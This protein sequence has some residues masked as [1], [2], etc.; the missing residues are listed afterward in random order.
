M[1]KHGLDTD[2][3]NNAVC[4]VRHWQDRE[5][6]VGYLLFVYGTIPAERSVCPDSHAQS[7][8]V[9][10]AMLQ[11]RLTSI[12]ESDGCND[13]K[14]IATSIRD[15]LQQCNRQIYELA[16]YLGQS[17]AIGGAVMFLHGDNC[18]ATVFGG[19]RMFFWDGSQL[20]PQGN[21]PPADGLITDALGTRPAWKNK[22]WHGKLNPGQ[23]FLCTSDILPDIARASAIIS[24]NGGSGSHEN[25]VAMLLRKE[26]ELR[27]IPP[28]AVFEVVCLEQAEQSGCTEEADPP[29]EF[30]AADEKG[31]VDNL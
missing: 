5:I 15:L 21:V 23:R 3:T 14:Y 8:Q 17:I 28:S 11:K 9:A 30:T 20:H 6:T 7:L 24:E 4:A 1:F 16:V 31:K 12:A 26:L 13:T 25:T 18:L 22:Y 2:T 10:E 29:Q 27:N 19:A